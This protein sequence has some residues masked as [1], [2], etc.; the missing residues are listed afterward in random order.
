MADTEKAGKRLQM[1]LDDADKSGYSLNPDLDFCGTLAEGLVANNERYGMEVCPCRLYMGE[2]ED[3][4][5][6]GCPCDYRDDDLTEHGACFC[7]LYVAEGFRESRQI[8]DRRPPL[9]RRRRSAG[10]KRRASTL[11]YPVYRCP[12]CGYLCAR[13]APPQVCP[14]CKA[15]GDR[16]ERFA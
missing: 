6:I 15:S 14:I 2:K 9:E 7:A 8:P 12:V 13:N 5:D 16:F 11:K 1:L 4:L 10:T 3:N